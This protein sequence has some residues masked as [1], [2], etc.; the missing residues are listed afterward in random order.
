M[1]LHHETVYILGEHEVEDGF[2]GV[3]VDGVE[4]KVVK[5]RDDGDIAVALESLS[6]DTAEYLALEVDMAIGD[7]HAY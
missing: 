6:Y 4:R 2:F 3:L 5:G 1:L 7:Y